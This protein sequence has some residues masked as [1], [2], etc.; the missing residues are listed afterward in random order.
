M[1]AKTHHRENLKTKRLLLRPFQPEDISDI[2]EM[3]GFPTWDQK[4]PKPF[5]RRH[6]EEYLAREILRSWN[7]E[8]AF[9]ITLNS[10][11]IGIIRLIINRED[12]TAEL[13]YSLN[14]SYWGQGIMQ[15]AA[16]KLLSW[17]FNEYDL[18]KISASA[19]IANKR[20][21][22]VM[23]TLGMKKEA[24]LRKGKVIRGVRTDLV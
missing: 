24:I 5:T 7:T 20:S 22:K 6:A 21:L 19:D 8:P 1:V 23:K 10:K 2:S 16:H 12:S 3:G 15:E 11:V 17:A 4:G 14:K 9:A 13:G 18:V